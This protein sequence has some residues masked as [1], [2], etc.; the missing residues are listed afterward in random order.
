MVRLL[1]NLRFTRL[2]SEILVRFWLRLSTTLNVLDAFLDSLLLSLKFITD[3]CTSSPCLHGNCSR[4]YREDDE[5]PSYICEC[6]EGYEG[7][8]CDQ[9][10]SNLLAAEPE[11]ADP[12][13][14]DLVT[15]DTSSTSTTTTTTTSAPHTLQP[16]Q[17]KPGQRLLVVPWEE[18]RVRQTV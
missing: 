18:S 8:R 2:H 5:E 10:L 13:P 11:T 7:E 14:T 9:I 3:P 15:L 16:W 1:L 4:T 17:P 12:F 6:A